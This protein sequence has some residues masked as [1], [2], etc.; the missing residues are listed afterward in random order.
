VAERRLHFAVD[1]DDDGSDPF[2]PAVFHTGR[3][4]ETDQRR[5]EKPESLARYQE[6]PPIKTGE[7]NYVCVQE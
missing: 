1:E 2:D 4:A 7:N 6:R 5:P 3:L